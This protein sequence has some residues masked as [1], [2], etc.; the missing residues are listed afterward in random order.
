MSSHAFPNEGEVIATGF[1]QM[2]RERMRW[3][4][5]ALV[6]TSEPD[7][8]AQ[9]AGANIHTD[10][11]FARSQGLSGIISDGMITTNWISS[12]LFSVFGMHYLSRG[13]LTTKYIKPVF[14]DERI[15]SRARITRI[16]RGDSST[17]YHLDVWCERADGVPV[18]VGTATVQV[19]EDDR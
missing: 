5:D 4:A 17:T 11:E 15:D 6:S 9:L 7:E 10:D 13:G 18:T 16:E 14:E 2:T 3:Y 8:V 19:S 1:R 12:L